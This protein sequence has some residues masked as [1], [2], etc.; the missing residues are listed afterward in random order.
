MQADVG[1]LGAVG[2]VLEPHRIP[3]LIEQL[4]GF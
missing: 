2:M 1:L 3:H 4:L